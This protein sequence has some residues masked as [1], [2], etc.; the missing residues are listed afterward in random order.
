METGHLR[1]A[2]HSPSRSCTARLR[3]AAG[4]SPGQ[5]IWNITLK[6]TG[7]QQPVTS[8]LPWLLSFPVK[9]NEGEKKCSKNLPCLMSLHQCGSI[10]GCLDWPHAQQTSTLIWVWFCGL[11]GTT[12]CSGVAL[13]AAGRASTCCRGCRFTCA[14]T[15][16]RSRSSARRRTAARSSPPLET[17]RITVAHT[18]VRKASGSNKKQD[19][20]TEPFASAGLVLPQCRSGWRCDESAALAPPF[21]YCSGYNLFRMAVRACFPVCGAD[22]T[23]VSL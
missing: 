23:L 3:A 1:L 4:H 18:Q 20:E 10:L 22:G 7:N 12:G 11:Q 17:W 21:H 5:L 19:P 6:H 9:K 16:A 15:T 2:A 8:L 14:L 13:R